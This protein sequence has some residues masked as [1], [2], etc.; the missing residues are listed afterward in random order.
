ML[1]GLPAVIVNILATTIST[2]ENIKQKKK[3]TAVPGAISGMSII[4]KIERITVNKCSF[5][6]LFGD[7]RYKTLQHPNR[8]RHIK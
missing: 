5:V 4:A 3:A 6:K 8:N 7:G 2:R 1:I